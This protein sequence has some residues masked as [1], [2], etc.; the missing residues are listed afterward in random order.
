VTPRRGGAEL[1]NLRRA[2]AAPA[3]NARALRH[4]ALRRVLDAVDLDAAERRIRDTLRHD[5]AL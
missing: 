1:A 4:G 3:G 5:L 2:P